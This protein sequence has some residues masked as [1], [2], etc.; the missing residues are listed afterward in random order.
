VSIAVPSVARPRTVSTKLRGL[1]ADRCIQILTAVVV[2]TLLLRF[3]QIHQS[4]FGDEVFTYA[5]IHGRSFRAVLTNVNTGAENSPPLFFLLA[6][7]TA[8]LGDPTVWIRL[9]S[10]VLG[11][12]TLVFVFLIGQETIGRR[13]G[14]LAAVLLAVSPFTLYY[15]VEARPYST[16]AF[17]V[18]VSTWALLRALDT[19]R[20]VYWATFTLATA[21]ATYSHYTSIFVLG[22]Q[23]I[24][25]LWLRRDRIKA[26]LIACVVAALL[27]V[28]WLPN[29]RGKGL[30]VIG[31]LE[32]LTPVHVLHDLA[33]PIAGYPY[34]A[35]TAIPTI[36]GLVVVIAC[37]LFGAACLLRPRLQARGG[38]ASAEPYRFWLLAALALATPVG[39][40]LYSML[41]TDLWLA[42]GLY[43][44]IPAGALVLAGLLLAIPRRFNIAAIVLV[45]AVLV[46]GLVRAASPSW[47]RPPT[48]SVASY[49][50]RMTS[51][52]DQLSLAAPFASGSILAEF[53]HR[54]HVV[55]HYALFQ[56]TR[57]GD[58]AVLVLADALAHD[59]HSSVEPAAPAGFTIVA[60]RHFDS[61]ILPIDVTIYR[62]V[63][64]T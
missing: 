43:A 61:A 60:H 26:P 10:I 34:A 1:A 49:I 13:A 30:S 42:R 18:S 50:D 45:L 14:V 47:R 31:Q 56:S 23:A 39:L 4:I 12:A 36:P 51:A 22:V 59:L 54:H 53:H 9:P 21:C 64:H 17:F 7:A 24:W 25:A 3:S 32:P 52:A 11:A 57:P 37:A 29:L 20:R 55:S 48:R 38:T 41:F 33:R 44:S 15:G 8:K 28:P 35:I 27:Y 6:Y 46:V 16:M 58:D 62:N 63:G 40:L 5:D 2:F 19:D